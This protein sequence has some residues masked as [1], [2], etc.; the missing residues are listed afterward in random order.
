LL[1]P[2]VTISRHLAGAWLATSWAA[3]CVSKA[4]KMQAPVPVMR[5]FPNCDSHFNASPTSG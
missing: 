2:F 4:A 5:A 1:R 3:D